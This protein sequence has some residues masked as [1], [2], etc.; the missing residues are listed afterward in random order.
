M[1]GHSASVI[2]FAT[3]S[4]LLAVCTLALLC[5]NL[6]QV[7]DYVGATAGVL[8]CYIG[9]GM[10]FAASSRTQCQHNQIVEASKGPCRPDCSRGGCIGAT[11]ASGYALVGLG[12]AIS[13]SFFVSICIGQAQ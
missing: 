12:I 13:V 5:S 10:L 3:V 9:P 1:P 2:A 6:S 7:F 4:L 11:A 8:V